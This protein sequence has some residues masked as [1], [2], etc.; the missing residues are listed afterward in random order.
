M[1]AFI[2]Q[3]PGLLSEHTVTTLA[4]AL[5]GKGPI[6][7]TSKNYIRFFSSGGVQTK[8]FSLPSIVCMT[9]IDEFAM[10]IYHI[11]PGLK[12]I[13]RIQLFYL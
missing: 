2:S 12:G 1:N 9:A 3:R 6:A 13:V 4:L 7:A 10:F 8:V 11:G 5:S